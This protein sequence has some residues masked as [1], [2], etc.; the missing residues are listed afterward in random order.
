[1]RATESESQ[2]RLLACAQ[3]VT[4]ELGSLAAEARILAGCPGGWPRA[5]SL[6]SQTLVSWMPSA[7]SGSMA[8]PTK[9][10]QGS[11]HSGGCLPQ[12]ILGW[13][14]GRSHPAVT[15]LRELL[16]LGKTGGWAGAQAQAEALAKLHVP[17]GEGWEIVCGRC[18]MQSQ[19]PGCRAAGQCGPHWSPGAL[20]AALVWAA[21]PAGGPPLQP[22]LLTGA[23]SAGPWQS[24]SHGPWPSKGLLGPGA[25]NR[26]GLELRSEASGCVSQHAR[27][28]CSS[29]QEAPAVRQSRQAVGRQL[30][31]QLCS[32]DL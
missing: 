10:E 21:S 24:C 32:Q 16:V 23:S 29:G 9:A 12:L 5:R 11:L 19:P 26:Q 28:A 4:L 22:L 25:S 1:M 6:C 15:Q 18:W 7:D 17:G 27:A 3:P 30:L 31:W 14:W 13:G 20:S 8:R 2:W